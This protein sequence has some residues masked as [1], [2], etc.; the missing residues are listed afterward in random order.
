VPTP[1]PLVISAVIGRIGDPANMLITAV[2]IVP[3]GIV[4]GDRRGFPISVQ[5]M[6]PPAFAVR[7]AGYI[8]PVDRLGAG[9]CGRYCARDSEQGT[10]S[11]RNVNF[12]M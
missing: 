4:I 1:V 8:T 2:G 11:K 7:I 5:V 3:I 12:L 9:S 10:Q 6:H